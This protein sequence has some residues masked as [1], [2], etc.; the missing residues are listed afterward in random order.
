M[1]LE[2]IRTTLPAEIVNMLVADEKV[3]YYGTGSGCLGLGPKSYIVV[4]DS[5]VL[6]SAIQPG[7]CIGGGSTATVDIPLE[8]V[9][10]TKT[11]T[12]GGCFGLFGT[13]TVEVA[14]GT[15]TNAFSTPNVQQA[16]TVIQHALREL[17]RR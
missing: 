8:H 1:A 7:G 5:R 11:G 14:S 6:G 2:D 12:T 17:K 13:Q 10:S 9:S 3:Y 4:T 16:A 15:A